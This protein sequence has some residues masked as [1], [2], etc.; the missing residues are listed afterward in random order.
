[1][2]KDHSYTQKLV[3]LATPYWE[4]EAEL[5]RRFFSSK[6]SKE[7]WISYLKAAVYKELNPVIGYGST[8]GYS[9]GLHMEFASLVDRFNSV[10][11]GMDRRSFHHRLEQMIEEFM[12]FTVLA[13][14]FED[15]LGRPLRRGDAKQLPQDDKLNKLRNIYVNSP[16]PAVRAVMELTEGGG[17]ATFRE[18]AKLTGGDFETKLAAAFKVIAD[19]EDGHVDHAASDLKEKVKSNDDFESAKNA[20][21]EV[22]MQRLHMRNEMFSHIMSSE[23]LN[24]YLTFCGGQ[25]VEV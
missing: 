13:E 24:S 23:E 15:L 14:V 4:T 5:T 6:P 12:H 7:I 3:D 19:D 18:G 20:L 25:T 17:T 11:D 2:T 16:N 8:D 1:M 21:L 9:C 10:D 22:S